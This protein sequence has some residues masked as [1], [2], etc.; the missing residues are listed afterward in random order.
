MKKN[1]IKKSSEYVYIFSNSHYK[2]LLKI[3]RTTNNPEVRAYQLSKQTGAIGE[4]KKVWEKEVDDSIFY[5]SLIHY[6]L[7]NYHSQKEY[8]EI[9]EDEAIA[10]CESI[11]KEFRLFK[12]NV[13]ARMQKI[14]IDK[15]S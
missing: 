4:F 11:T 9:S 2:G 6:L 13:K 5:E 3:G 14:R 1:K 15:L 12:A 10:C 8:F 7:E